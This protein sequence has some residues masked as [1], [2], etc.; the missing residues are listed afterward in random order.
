MFEQEQILENPTVLIC[1]YGIVGKNIKKDFPFAHTYDV[2]AKAFPDYTTPPDTTYDIAF[3][4]V[5]TPLK[6]NRCDTTYVK[7]VLSTVNANIYVIKS[8]IPP[9][10]TNHLKIEFQKRIVFSP[11]Y[12]G[13]THSS[14]AG[15]FV[16][17]GGDNKDVHIIRQLYE[18]VKGP[19]LY[20]YQCSSTEAEIIKYMENCFLGLKVVFCNQ[21]KDIADL[22]GVSYDAIREGFILDKRVGKS[23]TLVYDKYRGYDSKCL[24]KDIPAFITEV[25]ERGM[26]SF[27]MEYVNEINNKI[28][29]R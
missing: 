22:Y 29:A 12:T 19:E 14:N 15:N 1:G 10:T 24:N 13:I 18:Q 5:P 8:T 7:Q 26:D 28:K 17:L 23:H 2:Y 20:I 6:D 16:I 25:K 9:E 3:I 21:F 27:I 11:E 4:S